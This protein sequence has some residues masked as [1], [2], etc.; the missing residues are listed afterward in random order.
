MP[1]KTAATPAVTAL[2]QAFAYFRT[3]PAPCAAGA[4]QTPPTALEQ[5]FAYFDEGASGRI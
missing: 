1:R 2:Q 5:M 3:E 4:A